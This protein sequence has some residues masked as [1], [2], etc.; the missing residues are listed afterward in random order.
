MRIN[1]LKL[2]IELSQSKSITLTAEKMHISQ[3]GLSQIITRIEQELNVVLFH[4]SRQGTTLSEAGQKTILK[5]KEIVE[6]YEELRAE[7]E[8][9]AQQQTSPVEGELTLYHSHNSGTAVLPRA[10][11]MF[12]A[13]YPNVNLMLKES[14]PLETIARIKD[15]PTVAGLINFPEAYYHDSEKQV[16]HSSPELEYKELFRDDLIV[17]I[18]KSWSL[19]KDQMALANDMVKRPMVYFDTK[20]YD[21]IISLIFQ[22]TEQPPKVFL[23][24]LNNE[25]FRQTILDGLAMGAISA[26][27]LSDH[28]LLKE[29]T[30]Q[31]P[32]RLKLVYT[33]VSAANSP[34]SIAAQKFLKCLELSLN[35]TNE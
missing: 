26:L 14:S 34:M 23:R 2:L 20:Q 15:D 19:S 12:K 21:E 16:L 33:W 10:L 29:S 4:R 18:P 11:K 24:T 27:E 8:E 13:K 6:K 1:D 22:K 32:F 30:V 25:L 28:R 17:C 31:S 35:P 5:A 3:Q 9:L 7:L